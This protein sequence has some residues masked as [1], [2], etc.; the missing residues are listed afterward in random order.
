LVFKDLLQ[1]KNL[2]SLKVADLDNNFQGLVEE[3]KWEEIFVAIVH[4]HVAFKNI[5]ITANEIVKIFKVWRQH[6]L[7]M[8]TT[9]Q[10]EL[11]KGVITLFKASEDLSANEKRIFKPKTNL[12]LV[13]KGWQAATDQPLQ[14]YTTPGSHFSQL[15]EPNVAIVGK[16]IGECLKH[17][18]LD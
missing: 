14:V 11:F 17:N 15:I 7:E 9:K 12:E 10:E 4:N 13:L 3:G 8:V 6:I 1:N 5:G 18:Y 16:Q 2:F